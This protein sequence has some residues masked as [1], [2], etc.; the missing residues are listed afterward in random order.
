MILC[1]DC[2]NTSIKFALVENEEIKKT[3]LIKTIRDKTSDEYA[4]SFKS[5]IGS[6][7]KIDGAIISSVVPLLTLSLHRAIEVAFNV[8]ALVVGKSLKTKLPIKIDNPNE[9]GADMLCGALAAKLKFG[10]ST[11]VADL[12]TATKIY[13]IDKNGSFIGGVITCGMEISLK[14]LVNSTSQL[15][16]TPLLVPNKII[17][18]NTKD[19][20]ESGVVYGHIFMIESFAKK[21]EQELGYKLKNILTGG[22][23]KVIK[24]SISGFYYDEYLIFKGLYEI[25]KMNEG[26]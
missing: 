4:Y 9:L 16:E 20:I 6:D 22:F 23:S 8:N 10:D 12:G 24:N 18:R 17:G 26:K 15:L 1:V 7:A 2:G 25:Y 3:Y 19:C 13:V 11:L 5:L 14:S 21:M